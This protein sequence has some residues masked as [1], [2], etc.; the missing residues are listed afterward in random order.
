MKIILITLCVCF[1]FQ[2]YSQSNEDIN[3]IVLNTFV[4]DKE[5]KLEAESKFQLED[6]LQQIAAENG[7]SGNNINPRFVIAVKVN[8]TRKDIISG[9]PNMI[10]IYGS[11]LFF[12]GDAIENIV[13]ESLVLP[14]RGVGINENKAIIEFISHI[15]AKNINFTDF[16]NKGKSKIVDY[17]ERECVFMIAKAEL[18]GQ[19]EKYDEA[20]YQ[21][22]QIP[23][24]CKR[25]FEKAY[26]QTKIVFQ[27]KID[28][29]CISSLKN[30]K[31][32]WSTNQ[33]ITG[34]SEAGEIIANISPL[35]S[36]YGDVL[37]FIELM[38]N[39][40]EATEKLEWNFKIK[41]YNDE[42]ILKEKIIDSAKQIA[43][44]YYQN[45]PKTFI[46]NLLR[47]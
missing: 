46:Y 13:Y 8:I 38:K 33:N 9:P 19:Q 45:Q 43:N 12:I 20:I 26:L 47:W 10:S 32:K 23:A 31:T 27:K 2:L 11:V 44:S 39:K 35:A 16:V 42:M 22:T 29:E 21:L 24:V 41:E 5:N 25:C 14:I 28:N 36:C 3:R 6:L 17:Y 34:A 1:T 4:I 37:N 15:R 40:I 7:V 18:L 30:A